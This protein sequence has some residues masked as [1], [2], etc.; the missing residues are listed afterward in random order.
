MPKLFAKKEL[1]FPYFHIKMLYYLAALLSKTYK[2]NGA[3]SSFGFLLHRF[4]LR[5]VL[6]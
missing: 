2:K 5:E 6:L 1:Q 4:I 3:I